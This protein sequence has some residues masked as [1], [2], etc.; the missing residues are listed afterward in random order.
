MTNSE[1]DISGPCAEK[2]YFSS[3]ADQSPIGIIII[4]KGCKIE[5]CNKAVLE[6]FGYRDTGLFMQD[7]C[8]ILFPLSLKAKIQ[9]SF[10]ELQSSNEHAEFE[11][12]CASKDGTEFVARFKTVPMAGD[13]H[14]NSKLICYIENAS[15]YGRH[16][17]NNEYDNKYVKLI[18]DVSDGIVIIQDQLIKHFNNK[19]VKLSGY[20]R[21]EVLGKSFLDFVSPAYKKIVIQNHLDRLEGKSVPTIYEIDIISSQGTDIPMEISTYMTEFAGRPAVLIILRDIAER[22]EAEQNLIQAKLVAESAN[23]AKS[24]F[25]ATMSHELRTPLNSIIGFSDLMMSGSIGEMNE[26]Q[27]KF[28]GNISSSGKHLLSLI[29]NVLDLSKIEA[30]KMDLDYEHLNVCCIIDEVKQLVSPLANKNGLKIEFFRDENLEHIYADRVRFKQILF[31]LASN[32]IKF[33][34]MGGKITISAKQVGSMAQF[35]VKDTGIGIAE[36]DKSKLFQPFVQLDSATNRFY[37][38]TGLG[39]SLVKRFVELHQGRI[40][41]ESEIG[42]G[43]SFTFELPL[44]VNED[45]EI[46][47]GAK[48]EEA[49][50]FRS[51]VKR[52]KT[53]HEITVSETNELQSGTVIPQIMEPQNARGDE[54]LILVV[55][56]DDASRELLEVTLL[57]EGYRVASAANGKA[58]LELANEIKPFAITLDI[59][60]PGMDGWGVLR[61]L[62][63]KEQTHKIPVIITSMLD[64]RELGIVWGAVDHFIK[65]IKKNILLGTLDKIKYNV[66]KSSLS[67]LVVDDETNAVELIAAMLDDEEFDVLTAYGGQD[68][69]DIAFAKHPDVIVLDLMMPDVSGFDV[70]KEL[71]ANPDTIDIPIIICTA[72]DLNLNDREVLDKNVLNIMHK[73]MF[74]RDDL[75]GFIESVQKQKV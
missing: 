17:E 34:P 10:K 38:G 41:F 67:V 45:S 29:N 28:M 7:S 12:T 9:K 25:L 20:K 24:D 2:E 64:E 69:I 54:L 47:A 73:G 70:V 32:A 21:E 58:A 16:I 72:K 51:K 1:K 14:E 5:Y 65:P 63:E 36:E 33:T 22:K 11:Q 39:L 43:T 52:I 37:E 23:R 46:T 55:E 3:I 53:I 40:W 49:V 66:S 61:Q 8:S 74:A 56:D 71:K 50:A 35:S 15:K 4:D 27:N 13:V 59:M 75:I 31:N 6:M 68:A 62:K 19:I 42:K 48:F 18:E 57:C 60:M 44:Q 30:L 26:K